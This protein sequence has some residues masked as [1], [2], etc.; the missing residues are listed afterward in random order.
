MVRQGQ[1]ENADNYPLGRNQSPGGKEM[2]CV[3]NGAVCEGDYY[4]ATSKECD[5]V[6]IFG[7]CF[8]ECKEMEKSENEEKK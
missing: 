6:F 7:D 2:N 3:I 5:R 4:C 8:P 1:Y